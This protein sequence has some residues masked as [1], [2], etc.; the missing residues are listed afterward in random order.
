MKNYNSLKARIQFRITLIISVCILLLSISHNA[1]SA[2]L[3]DA[4]NYNIMTSDFAGALSECRKITG[5]EAGL[6]EAEALAGLGEFANA[7]KKYAELIEKYADSVEIYTKAA[8]FHLSRLDFEKAGTVYKKAAQNIYDR[9]SIYAAQRTAAEGLFSATLDYYSRFGMRSAEVEF[10]EKNA[11]SLHEAAPRS[12]SRAVYYMLDRKKYDRASALIES[13]KKVSKNT[14]LISECEIALYTRLILSGEEKEKNVSKVCSLY[15]QAITEFSSDFDK[16]ALLLTAYYNFLQDNAIFK[17]KT[18]EL[19]AGFDKASDGGRLLLINLIMQSGGASECKSYISRYLTAGKAAEKIRISRILRH[20]G[21]H[22]TA[23]GLAL[24]ALGEGLTPAEEPDA[25]YELAS[26]LS[27]AY[28]IDMRYLVFKNAAFK[29][30]EKE[31]C[32][33]F[34]LNASMAMNSRRFFRH[35]FDAMRVTLRQLISRNSALFYYGMILQKYPGVKYLAKIQSDLGSLYSSLGRM[36]DSFAAYKKLCDDHPGSPYA[37]AALNNIITHYGGLYSGEELASRSIDAIEGLIKKNGSNSIESVKEAVETLINRLTYEEKSAAVY[38]AY[39]QKVVAYLGSLLKTRPADRYLKSKYFSV[40]EKLHWRFDKKMEFIDACLKEDRFDR[41]ALS[42]KERL[43]SSEAVSTSAA[44]SFYKDMLNKFYEQYFFVDAAYQSKFIENLSRSG[45]TGEF[46]EGRKAVSAAPRPC[47]VRLLADCLF[48]VSRFEEAEKYY[49]Q[50]LKLAPSDTK[51]IMRLSNLKRSFAKSAEALA[52]LMKHIEAAPSDKNGYVVAGDLLA[53]MNRWAEAETYFKKLTVIDPENNDN[54]L[55]LAT[56]YWDYFKYDDGLAVLNSRRGSS[57]GGFIFGREIAGLFELTDSV[58]VAVPEYISV[59]C[60]PDEEEVSD[61]PG[62]DGGI[63]N[64]DAAEGDEFENRHSERRNERR[65][66]HY[67]Y[68]YERTESPDIIEC[69]ARLVKLYGR[70]KIKK[71]I[72]ASFE[73]LISGNPQNFKLY[74]EYSRMLIEYGHNE[75]ASIFMNQALAA[76]KKGYQFIQLASVFE[77]IKKTGDAK[78]CYMKAIEAEPKNT[79]NYNDAAEFFQRYS[80]TADKAEVMKLRAENFSEDSYYLVDYTKYLLEQKSQ[81]AEVY[82]TA[83]NNYQRLIDKYP[84][85]VTYR[86]MMADIKIKTGGIDSAIAYIAAVIDESLKKGKKGFS[87]DD[88]AKL[89]ETRAKLLLK[90]KKTDEALAVYSGLIYENPAEASFADMLARTAIEYACHEKIEAFITGL[91]ETKM[92][93]VNR[94]MML[95]RFYSGTAKADKT[96]EHYRQ[97]LALVPRSRAALSE[98]FYACRKFGKNDECKKTIPAF[99]AVCE[100][101]NDVSL[102]DRYIDSVNVYL[103]TGDTSSADLLY[104]GYAKKILDEWKASNQKGYCSK[105]VQVQKRY[106]SVLESYSYYA[107]AVALLNDILE[108]YGSDAYNNKYYIYETLDDIC[109]I[110]M[111]AGEYE[112]A[113]KVLTEDIIGE[114]LKNQETTSISGPHFKKAVKLWKMLGKYDEALKFYRENS[115]G[116]SAEAPQYGKLLLGI[117]KSAGDWNAYIDLAMASSNSYAVNEMI[118]RFSFSAFDELVMKLL[119]WSVPRLESAKNFSEAV[120]CLVKCGVI[121]E[122]KGCPELAA[123]FFGMALKAAPSND[124]LRNI[125][126][127]L[128]AVNANEPAARYYKILLKKYSPRSYRANAPDIAMK[129]ASAGRSSDAMDIAGQLLEKYADDERIK[130]ECARIFISAGNRDRGTALLSDCVTAAVAVADVSEA[131]NGL[132]GAC[133]PSEFLS[134]IDK[135]IAGRVK[136]ENAN[137]Y[138]FVFIKKISAMAKLAGASNLA[139]IDSAAAA[140]LSYG[141]SAGSVLQYFESLFAGFGDEF[142]KTAGFKDVY[143]KNAG[144]VIESVN[145][146]GLSDALTAEENSRLLELVI[147]NAPDTVNFAAELMPLL[148]KLKAATV[149]LDP[150][151][152]DLLYSSPV[153]FENKHEQMFAFY[154]ENIEVSERTAL[155]AAER[156]LASGHFTAALKFSAFAK[157]LN[158]ESETAKLFTVESLEGSGDMAQAAKLAAGINPDKLYMPDP[159]EGNEEYGVYYSTETEGYKLRYAKFLMRAGAPDKAGP[160]LKGLLAQMKERNRYDKAYC[161][162]KLYAEALKVYF[163]A[164]SAA[165]PADEFMSAFEEVY[166]YR[167]GGH[168]AM[169]L[170][171][172]SGIE[173]LAAVYCGWKSA[174]KALKTDGDIN[175]TPAKAYLDISLALKRNDY[176]GAEK[177]L[178][179]YTGLYPADPDLASIVLDNAGEIDDL[180]LI[181]RVCDNM[182]YIDPAGVLKYQQVY[183]TQ[184]SA[185]ALEIKNE[186][187]A[188]PESLEESPAEGE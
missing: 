162:V 69:R 80:M 166:D 89:S 154:R 185:R 35:T 168:D 14:S 97:A 92:K 182:K 68:R 57:A 103:E 170:Y 118:R 23:A 45:K 17:K 87:A 186:E 112:K 31:G 90:A 157:K 81:S 51:A 130:L 91:D 156:L 183:M 171:D 153:V 65:Y 48:F 52:L 99:L 116:A 107:S 40:I 20:Y 127:S 11:L 73:K 114:K 184:F 115:A 61:A 33:D 176:K 49:E 8:K 10:Y 117:Y 74:Y 131:V 178:R 53:S 150:S 62:Y 142:K 102:T 128:F 106:A 174:G 38:D 167:A 148:L 39:Y 146:K 54:Y 19:K 137:D 188:A 46:I 179:Y 181:G 30:V 3:L 67:N 96:L 42:A 34:L 93:S 9:P 149:N 138:G 144:L 18:D 104:S 43:I 160:V 70:E 123:S 152:I 32:G 124:T 108:Q 95:A 165:E 86:N 147:K 36:E 22:F 159:V 121:S 16:S 13:V 172:R 140:Y 94:H 25:Y 63:E 82:V 7:D 158:D 120:S 111:K 4:V 59:I 139:A 151:S 163:E 175:L 155:Q 177:Q 173:E 6:L 47:D 24:T 169:T 134:K 133:E 76:A 126:E 55:E 132:E 88:I 15:E 161:G 44:A 136:K 66:S 101:E 105:Y 129:F 41:Q 29:L 84:N 143:I 135:F 28:Y 50:Y 119:L 98:L 78:K 75:K 56:I 26:S 37:A 27:S 141:P 71:A 79:S 72:D 145:K 60:A 5:A 64:G 83:G 180:K 164:F 58:E 122:K 85:N 77:T 1:F 109:D 110:H 187:A 2:P 21:E 113:L 100:A 12:V 125:A